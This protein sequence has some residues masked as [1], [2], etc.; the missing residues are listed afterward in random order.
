[1]FHANPQCT[2]LASVGNRLAGLLVDF[3]WLT[4]VL[5]AASSVLGYAQS[6]GFDAD[7]ALAARYAPV[8][9]QGLGQTPRFDYI[10]NFDFD[11]DWRGDNNWQN[12]DDP[13]FPLAAWVYFSVCETATHYFIHYAVFHPRDWKGVTAGAW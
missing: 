2:R 9:Y 6:P 3:C 12:A 1:M 13:R 5:L 10:T 4:W 11:G 7:L 8:F